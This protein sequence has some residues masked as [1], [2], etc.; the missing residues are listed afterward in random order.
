MRVIVSVD[1]GWAA[2]DERWEILLGALRAAGLRELDQPRDLRSSGMVAGDLPGDA[3]RVIEQ[4]DGVVAVSP[5]ADRATR[6]GRRARGGRP[7]Q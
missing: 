5:D 2:S 4:V 7:M 3:L 1:H 6:G